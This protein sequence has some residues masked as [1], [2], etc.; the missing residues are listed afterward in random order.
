MII[1]S[2]THILPDEFRRDK[3]RFLDRDLTFRELFSSARAT[4][5]SGEDLLSAMSESGVDKSV[6][7]GYGWTDIETACASND[8][9][10]EYHSNGAAMKGGS[11]SEVSVDADA[12]IHIDEDVVRFQDCDGVFLRH[13]P[14]VSRL[15][16]LCAQ[17]NTD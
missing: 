11:S 12:T 1:D 6:A 4:S 16:P 9:I 5:A 13:S 10:L 7:C 2:H 8:Y 17:I 3:G 15:A 14:L